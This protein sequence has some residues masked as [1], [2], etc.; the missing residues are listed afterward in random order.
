MCREGRNARGLR[1]RRPLQTAPH[2]AQL[3]PG[4]VS[5]VAVG[6]LDRVRQ[7]RGWLSVF[8]PRSQGQGTIQGPQV[9]GTLELPGGA[10][11]SNTASAGAGEAEAERVFCLPRT[12]PSLPPC[13]SATEV[14]PKGCPV[15]ASP[16]ASVGMSGE[17]ARRKPCLPVSAASGPSLR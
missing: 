7:S 14:P 15:P 12:H 8:L 4:R 13:C 17:V 10:L 2:W 16:A 9:Q 1:G 5:P 11:S 3:E 6:A